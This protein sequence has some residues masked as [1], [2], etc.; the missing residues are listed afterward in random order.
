MDGIYLEKSTIMFSAG[1]TT[2]YFKLEKQAR[3]GYPISAYLFILALEILFYMIKTNQ[4][5]E[6][7]DICGYSFLYSAY[8]D[9][10]TFFLKNMKSVMELLDTTDHSSNYSGLNLNIFNCEIAGV[11]ALKEV[12]AAASGLKYVDLTSPY[13]ISVQIR[14]YFW[15]E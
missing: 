1:T 7:L 8:A 12:H 6:R 15:S 13:V 3:Q 4:D 9:D 10:T 5:L 14:S 2:P 11:G